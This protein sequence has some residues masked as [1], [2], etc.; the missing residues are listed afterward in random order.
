MLKKGTHMLYITAQKVFL[1]DDEARINYILRPPKQKRNM[2]ISSEIHH[3]FFADALCL[4]GSDNEDEDEFSLT[5]SGKGF[6]PRTQTE[7]EH[8]PVENEDVDADNVLPQ[9]K[10]TVTCTSKKG[11][12]CSEKNVRTMPGRMD[13]IFHAR[14]PRAIAAPA[15]NSL[16]ASHG[17]FDALHNSHSTESLGRKR[18]Q[19]TSIDE[20]KPVRKRAPG[21]WPWKKSL[22]LRY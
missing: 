14:I 10:S 22:A 11:E 7:E 6:Q 8:N 5:A 16:T 17:E 4:D 21:W 2:P 13:Q 12:T 1:S 18:R 15:R 9:H 19:S 3:L 20:R